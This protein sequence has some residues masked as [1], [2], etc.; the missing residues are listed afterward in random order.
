ML[1]SPEDGL[2]APRGT[3]KEKIAR[4]VLNRHRE[5]GKFG[6][7]YTESSTSVRTLHPLRTQ[8]LVLYRPLRSFSV[9]VLKFRNFGLQ[10]PCTNVTLPSI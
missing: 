2:K 8:K 4:I 9:L 10:F 7:V 3:I 5:A 1:R 6:K